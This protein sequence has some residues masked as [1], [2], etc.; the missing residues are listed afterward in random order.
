MHLKINNDAIR[1][2]GIHLAGAVIATNSRQ[3]ANPDT[4]GGGVTGLQG[5]FDHFAA[6][7]VDAVGAHEGDEV[8][9]GVGVAEGGDGLLKPGRRGRLQEVL[10]MYRIVE[11]DTV[12][13]YQC[14]IRAGPVIGFNGPF[15]VIAHVCPLRWDS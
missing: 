15:R 8:V 9:V 11:K 14:F 10:V 7:N 12:A 4:F 13:T 5:D 6:F 3:E 1:H 2:G